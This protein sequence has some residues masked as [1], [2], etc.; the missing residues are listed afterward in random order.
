MSVT[1]TRHLY[2][3]RAQRFRSLAIGGAIA[4]GGGA[5]LAVKGGEGIVAIV[6]GLVVVAWGVVRGARPLVTIEPTSI[7]L[8]FAARKNVPFFEIARVDVLKT[9]THDLEL[10]LRSGAK[11]VIPMEPFEDDDAAWLRRELRKEMRMAASRR[12]R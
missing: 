8:R 10:C 11:H 1:A 5:L 7:V 6:V 9:K 12:A 4:L 2:P 3:K